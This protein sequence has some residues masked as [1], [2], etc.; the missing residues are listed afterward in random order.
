MNKAVL[1]EID[2]G[3]IL[4]NIKLSPTLDVQEVYEL[5][6]GEALLPGVLAP[7]VDTY[8]VEN[9]EIVPAPAAEIDLHAIKTA[10]KYRVDELA[11][12]ERNRIASSGFGQEMTYLA[13]EAQARAW[14]AAESPDNAAYP[15]P[16]AEIGITAPDMRSVCELIVAK[17]DEWIA[18]AAALEALRLNSKQQIDAATS[19]T[20]IDAI[21]DGIVWP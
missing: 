19:E 14:L 12:T 21:R 17:A 8:A 5:A 6:D 9:G 16:F 11:G 4:A 3:K 18:R 20:E 10:A 1:Y 15:L 13:K 7:D 2:T